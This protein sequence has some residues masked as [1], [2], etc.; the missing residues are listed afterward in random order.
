MFTF[1]ENFISI[2]GI[3]FESEVEKKTIELAENYVE[4]GLIEKIFLDT[5]QYINW[6]KIISLLKTHGLVGTRCGSGYY[7]DEEYLSVVV[8]YELNL[9]ETNASV[10]HILTGFKN[11]PALKSHLVKLYL[12]F[13]DKPIDNESKPIIT[14]G[15]I[16]NANYGFVN[17]FI[18]EIPIYFTDNSNFIFNNLD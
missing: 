5:D 10:E 17:P 14:V 9:E 3:F 7:C 1:K 2:R 11:F 18:K 6:R 4:R 8:S 13:V 12:E 16:V 15:K